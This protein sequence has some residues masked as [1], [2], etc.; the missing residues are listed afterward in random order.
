MKFVISG[1][2]ET[3][4]KVSFRPNNTYF[5]HNLLVVRQLTHG[6]FNVQTTGIDVDT[7]NQMVYFQVMEDK[8][9]IEVF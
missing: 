5:H 1:I 7:V 2:T 8:I 6:D 9:F 4:K 3:D